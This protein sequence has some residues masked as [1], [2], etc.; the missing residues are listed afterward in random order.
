[1]ESWVTVLT[2]AATA[3]FLDALLAHVLRVTDV[4]LYSPNQRWL[5]T[6][7]LPD[8]WFNNQNSVFWFKS[9]CES[10]VLNPWQ[11][12]KNMHNALRSKYGLCSY[13][14]TRKHKIT[15]WQSHT[16]TG[17]WDYI[18]TEHCHKYTKTTKDNTIASEQRKSGHEIKKTYSN[19][20]LYNSN[21]N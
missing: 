21:D 12:W 3:P 8:T 19:L 7:I 16:A 10:S 6:T 1:M 14:S 2:S 4:R 18:G 17:Q 9:Q 15:L 11:I 13:D 20:S 5:S